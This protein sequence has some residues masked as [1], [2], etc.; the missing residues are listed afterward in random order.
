M[1]MGRRREIE[2]QV[3]QLNRRI[4]E[5]EGKLSEYQ[6]KEKAIVEA[7]TQAQTAAAQR[8]AEAENRAEEIIKAAD[9]HK[10]V[11]EE[12]SARAVSDAQAQ[13]DAIIQEAQRTAEA[14]LAQ[15]DAELQAHAIRMKALNDNMALTAGQAR[16]SALAFAKLMDGTAID[17]DELAFEGGRGLSALITPVETPAEYETPAELMHSIYEIQNRDIPASAQMDQGA[18]SEEAKPAPMPEEE[19]ESGLK[20]QEEAPQAPEER[21]W[22]VDEVIKNAAEQEDAVP[23]VD[24]DS[25]LNEIIGG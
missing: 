7:L 21:V 3:E 14:L 25:L 23:T 15:S 8:V 11:R 12:E 18:P 5:L 2:E 19:P 16:E 1:A 4:V 20:A 24:F 22:T 10:A 9:A 13:A 17:Q 6:G